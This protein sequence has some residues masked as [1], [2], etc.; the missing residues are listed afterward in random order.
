LRFGVLLPHYGEHC[1]P[2]KLIEGS[3][4]IEKLGYDNVWVRDHLIWKPHG[5]EG[6]NNTFVDAFVTLAAVAGATKRVGLGT[7]VVIPIRWPLKVAQNFAALSF[8]SGGR[9]V[10]AGF[11]M[12]SNHAELAAAGFSADDREQI[13]IESVQICNKMWRESGVTWNGDYFQFEDV[14]LEPK[15][16]GEIPTWYGGTTRASCRRA[17]AH[18]DGWLPGRLPM[19]TFDDRLSLLQE[20]GEERGKR[21]QVGVI[22]LFSIDEDRDL[23]RKDIDVDALANSSEGSKRWIKPPSGRFETV[24]DLEGLVVA[25]TPEDC[26]AEIKKFEERGVDDFIFDLRLQFENYEEKLELIAREVLPHVQSEAQAA[27]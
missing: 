13:F 3:Q 14:T 16:T 4:L 21:V 15:P 22:P 20:L 8:I 5:M 11:G 18:C 1:T 27:A 17:A 7:A 6:T 9:R 23:A 2:E 26:V 25:G 12:G 10:D 19:A 24:E